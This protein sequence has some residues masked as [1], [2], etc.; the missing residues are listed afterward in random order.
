MNSLR[1]ITLLAPKDR[2]INLENPEGDGLMLEFSDDAN[3][4]DISIDNNRPSLVVIDLGAFWSYQ[5]TT[6]I[7]KCYEYQIPVL[8][9]LPEDFDLDLIT[10]LNL[11]DFIFCP[12]TQREF[13][14]RIQRL[15]SRQT[16]VN[17]S[18]II[19]VGS[20][21]IDLDSY[22]VTISGDK[23]I[24]TYKEF[25]LLCLMANTPGRVYSREALLSSVWGYD[26][27]GGTRTVD[28]HIRRLRS[29]IENKG[30]IFIDTIRNVGYRFNHPIK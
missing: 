1:Q 21:R 16:S 12:F 8:G 26:Y 18:S 29:K 30:S 3:S 28:V 5:C 24:L 23:V 17:E 13:K 19:R 22:E 27:F 20:M 15:I 11:S 6:I 14:T 7:Q 25:Q 10:S 9:I 2:R 4:V